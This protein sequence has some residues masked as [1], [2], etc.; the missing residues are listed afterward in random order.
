LTHM[1][2]KIS[3]ETNATPRKQIL[4]WVFPHQLTYCITLVLRGD[5]LD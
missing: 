4:M 5:A 1:V 2:E 3:L